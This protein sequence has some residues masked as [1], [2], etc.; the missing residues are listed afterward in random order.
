[1]DA[2]E[3]VAEVTDADGNVTTPAVEA[4]DAVAAKD[5]TWD[6]QVIDV[7]ISPGTVEEPISENSTWAIYDMHYVGTKQGFSFATADLVD[8]TKNGGAVDTDA[9]AA[10][11]WQMS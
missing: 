8:D 2:V 1:M 10:T 4:V 3:A 6:C 5:E 7:T 9:R 11:N